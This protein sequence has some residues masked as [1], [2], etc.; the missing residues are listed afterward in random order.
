MINCKFTQQQLG[1]Y[2]QAALSQFPFHPPFVFFKV[3]RCSLS[4]LETCFT[5]LQPEP[6]SYPQGGNRVG[7]SS[8]TLSQNGTTVSPSAMLCLM[9]DST[10]RVIHRQAALSQFPFH[11][12][13]VFFKVGRCS[14][15]LLE[16]CFTDLQ[17]EPVSYPFLNESNSIPSHLLKRRR[18]MRKNLT[19]NCVVGIGKGENTCYIWMMTGKC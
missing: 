11:P 9:S 14:L 17:S 8:S 4:L 1:F 16:T 19:Q 5:D 15:G 3:G 12:P 13:F 10:L 2:G 18:T 6:V 7:K